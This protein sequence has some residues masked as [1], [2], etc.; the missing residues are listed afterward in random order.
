MRK[1]LGNLQN[2]SKCTLVYRT[3]KTGLRK[4]DD[5]KEVIAV[6][7]LKFFMNLLLLVNLSGKGK[8]ISH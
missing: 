7:I 8:K 3:F 2:R 1:V 5:I 4:F 6:P